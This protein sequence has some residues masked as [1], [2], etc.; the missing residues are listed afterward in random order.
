[1]GWA[2]ARGINSSR[3]AALPDAKLVVRAAG[4]V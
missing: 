2:A 4:E 3:G 1:M